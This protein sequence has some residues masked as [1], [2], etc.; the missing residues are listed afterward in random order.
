MTSMEIDVLKL[1]AGTIKGFEDNL[2]W[3]RWLS[4]C[5]SGEKIGELMNVRKG[6]QM[7]MSAAQKKGLVTESLAVTFARWTNSIDRTEKKI[8]RKREG[9]LNH[10]DKKILDNDIEK[11][12]KRESY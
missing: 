3:N 12:F 2:A 5:L 7:G 8:I 6:I 1:Y 10:G 11:F 9:K 4:I